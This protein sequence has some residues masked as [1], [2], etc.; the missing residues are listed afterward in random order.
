[1]AIL[2]DFNMNINIDKNKKYWYNNRFGLN[3]KEVVQ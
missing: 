2:F 1:M 3:T